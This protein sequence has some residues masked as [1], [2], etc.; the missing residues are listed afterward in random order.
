MYRLSITDINKKEKTYSLSA[1]ATNLLHTIAKQ[2]ISMVV[3]PC[4][5]KNPNDTK[6]FITE[7]D[8]QKI[9]AKLFAKLI[10]H[11]DSSESFPWKGHEYSCRAIESYKLSREK[12]LSKKRKNQF[13]QKNS[14]KKNQKKN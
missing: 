14:K 7:V 1:S 12:T 13:V 8:Y 10:Q 9:C 5:E 2:F 3:E 4:K 6:K 11:K